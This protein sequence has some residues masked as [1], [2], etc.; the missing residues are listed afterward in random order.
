MSKKCLI[1]LESSL[2][3]TE[4]TTTSGKPIVEIIKSVFSWI[5]EENNEF[6]IVCQL[7]FEVI[8]EI[9][10]FEQSLLRS[11]QKLESRH[12]DS[13]NTDDKVVKPSPDAYVSDPNQSKDTVEHETEAPKK[14]GYM[15]KLV[16]R[17][18]KK[19]IL[20]GIEYYKANLDMALHPPEEPAKI[21]TS[22]SDV[23]ATM[24]NSA[25]KTIEALRNMP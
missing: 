2:L 8:D 5:S 14:K 17:G 15:S 18:R 1:C 24:I 25:I 22:F 21:I 10:V 23:N 4:V 20:E 3:A 6:S 12:F 7:C 16:Q 13:K 9:D 11:K 19:S